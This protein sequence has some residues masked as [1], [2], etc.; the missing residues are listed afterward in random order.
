MDAHLSEQLQQIFGAYVRQDTLD[1]AAAEMA[2]VDA[3]SDASS[4]VGVC[5]HVVGCCHLSGLDEQ[6][7]MLRASMGVR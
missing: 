3:P 5:W 2:S 7:H 6:R 4:K 1:T